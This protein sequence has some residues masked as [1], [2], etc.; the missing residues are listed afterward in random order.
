[1]F[2]F[3]IS[4]VDVP[5]HSCSTS[6]LRVVVLGYWS[7]VLS[8]CLPISSV[9]TSW[10]T[11]K[12]T[13]YVVGANISNGSHEDRTH[14]GNIRGRKKRVIIARKYFHLV[15]ILLFAPVT[16]L[17]PDMMALS[18]GIAIALLIVLEMVRGWTFTDDNDWEAGALSDFYMIFLDEKDSSA[19]KGGLAVTHIALIVGCAFPLWASQLLHPTDTQ[20]A[21]L[22]LLPFLGVVVLGIG[23]SAGAIGGISFGH[24]HWSGGSSR[25]LEG[26]FCIFLSVLIVTNICM[27]NGISGENERCLHQIIEFSVPVL[28]ITLVEA[29]TTQIDNLCLPIAGSTLVLLMTKLGR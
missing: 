11:A 26:S 5:W 16:W 18:Y 28:I 15:A 1:M 3:L 13:K 27:G 19:A 21:F 8:V 17:D 20:D 22:A 24:Y 14:E 9:L 10:I 23:D 4:R 2:H 6:I 7:F 12:E 29:S 25:T